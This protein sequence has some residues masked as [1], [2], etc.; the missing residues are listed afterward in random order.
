LSRRKIT[1]DEFVARVNSK[2][3]HTIAVLSE[4]KGMR[5]PVLFKHVVNGCGYEWETRAVN[6]AILGCGCPIC[7][8]VNK[9]LNQRLTHEE[10][11]EKVRL[12]HGDEIEIVG[13]YTRSNDKILFKHNIC[14]HVWE[15]IPSAVASGRGCPKCAGKTF[16]HDEFVDR[17]NEI[18]DGE[19]EVLD[20]Y[21]NL[22]TKIKF[23]HKTC[24]HVWEATPCSVMSHANGC[25]RCSSSRG[26]KLVRRILQNHNITFQEQY[27]FSDCRNKRSL[28]FDFAVFKNGNL[29][30]LI[31]YQGLQHYKPI[32]RFGGEA[33]FRTRQLNDNIKR[34]YCNVNNIP[35]LH[36][37]YW[38]TE[39]EVYKSI[40][41]ML[42][43]SPNDSVGYGR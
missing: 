27:R 33:A 42:N 23:R 16:N 11:V 19:I 40:L 34:T 37:P 29:L 5:S 18:H 35:L 2:H 26:E 4:Y 32:P 28:P 14:G 8:N 25:P 39:S 30:F 24:G 7:S 38:L 36:I 15:A 20:K 21:I 9:G 41:D 22:N 13:Q 43:Q 6:V 17:I 10:F 31:E 3:D 12:K 1:H